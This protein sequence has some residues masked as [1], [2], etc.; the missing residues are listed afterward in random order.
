[1]SRGKVEARA[2]SVNAVVGIVGYGFRGDADISPGG[3]V[4][5][6]GVGYGQDSDCDRRLVK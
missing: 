3:G 5:G 4:G 6:G 2:K 1:M